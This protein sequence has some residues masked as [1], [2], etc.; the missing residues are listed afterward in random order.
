MHPAGGC[1]VAGIRYVTSYVDDSAYKANGL[2]F[3]TVKGSGK[4]NK[5]HHHHHHNT[6]NHN[7]NNNNHVRVVVLS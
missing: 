2:T 6:S 1:A 5:D 4:C 3:L 7:N